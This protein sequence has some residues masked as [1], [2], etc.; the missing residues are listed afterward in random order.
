MCLDLFIESIKNASRIQII[1]HANVSLFSMNI[2]TS[3]NLFYFDL[4]CFGDVIAICCFEYKKFAVEQN[5]TLQKRHM[6]TKKNLC[7]GFFLN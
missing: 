2:A 1:L 7:T 3:V 6:W 4:T 5:T